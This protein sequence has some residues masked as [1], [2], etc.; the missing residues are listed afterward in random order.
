MLPGAAA[1]TRRQLVP[2]VVVVMRRTKQARAASR[3]L[4]YYCK[5]IS[6]LGEIFN[7]ADG[8]D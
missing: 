6:L 2:L 7:E 3:A 5:L 8:A 4:P 1:L